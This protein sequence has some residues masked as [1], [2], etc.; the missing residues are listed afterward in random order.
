MVKSDLFGQNCDLI[1]FQVIKLTWNRFQWIILKC[2]SNNFTE[3]KF[4][5]AFL[6][7]LACTRAVST[8]KVRPGMMD[9]A[10]TVNVWT[11]A[12]DCINV[13]TGKLS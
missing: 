7:L 5:H 12:L 1:P 9:V 2:V 8:C 11:Q 10:T 4:L 3:L 6:Q 13:T